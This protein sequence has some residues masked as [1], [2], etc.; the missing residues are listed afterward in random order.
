MTETS[1]AVVLNVPYREPDIDTK[2]VDTGIDFD[3]KSIDILKND[4]V[5][6][7]KTIN[8]C[9]IRVVDDFNR[10]L[11]QMKVG[12]I[13]FKGEFLCKG[14][15][16]KDNK[17]LFADGWLCTGDIGFLSGQNLY[18]VGRKKDMFFMHGKNIYMR[19]IEQIIFERYG[20]RS[21][22]CGENN[23][24]E[25]KSKIY[26]FM[27]LEISSAEYTKKKKEII[28]FIQGETGIKLSDVIFKDDMF[29]TQVFRT[30][31]MKS[32]AVEGTNIELYSLLSEE[33]KP[34]IIMINEDDEYHYVVLYK[35]NNSKVFLWDPNKGKRII[36]KEYF[37]LIWSSYAI[38]ITEILEID[39]VVLPK[40]SVCWTAL[41]QQ[42][43]LLALLVIFSVILMAISVITTFLYKN[44]IDQIEIGIP[45]F[46]PQLKSF[47]IVMGG[48]YLL[49]SILSIV[50]G[51]LIAYL[52]MELEITLQNQFVESLLNIS[53][54][55]KDDYTSGGVLDRYYRL[56]VVVETMSSVFSFVVLECISLI[57]GAII[58]IGI[59][60]IM[61][62]LVLVIVAA[63]II[64]F[65]ISKQ[66][67]FKLSKTIMDKESLLITHIKETIENLMSLKSFENSN[68]MKKMRKE[69][70]FVKN[71]EYILSKLSIILGETLRAI[72]HMVMLIILAYGIYSVIA[73]NM[74]LGTLLAFESFIGFFLSPVKNLLGILPSLQETILTF[75][76]I[77]D[78][79]AYNKSTEISESNNEISGKICVDNLDIAYGYDVPILK[80]ISFT[81]EAGE[82]VFL[83]GS[84]GCGKSTLAKTIA[85]L[86]KYNKGEIVWG[87]DRNLNIS[88]LSKQVLYLS[89][90][91]EIFS[92]SIQENILMWEKDCNQ[93]LF[94]EVIEAMGIS[95]MM[96][97]RSL[98]L[99]SYLSENG[100]NLSGGEKQRVA[101]ARAMMR[102]VPIYIF[103]E[104]T[105]HLDFESEN[106]IIDYIRKKLLEQTCIIISH[107]TNL[108]NDND[109]VLFIDSTGK[110]H[111][112]KHSHLLEN[113]LEYNQIIISR[114]PE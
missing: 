46:T 108:L 24:M 11:G 1:G 28:M 76:R 109:I 47:F 65:V 21:A 12:N 6:Q 93:L 53:I 42:K 38:I 82:K 74:S 52:K 55:K 67:L 4:L 8:G 73:G 34:I 56:S 114:N 49:V 16:N 88:D 45:T 97:S 26:L 57:A 22:A 105:C 112:N 41:F 58:L 48:C 18:I 44:I 81:I 80:N 75:R 15:L 35:T 61:F 25:E 99:D 113:N 54:Q 37:D 66:K 90:E 101:L 33:K 69:I 5:C 27:E 87:N 92:G 31:G 100:T 43:K 106:L 7:G 40:K 20:V 29:M 59:S 89:Q 102:N 86:V 50:K 3:L 63:Y 60:P 110:L 39:R 98:S 23:A 107:N 84:S 62:Y 94:D 78:I 70:K 95:Q 19:D 13:Q 103:D 64:S 17:D 96:S 85:G 104:A 68:Y 72:E 111:K 36:T 71:Q 79:F 83:M 91:S 77:E 9:S 14:Y 10:D 2:Q 30:I 32:L 51:K